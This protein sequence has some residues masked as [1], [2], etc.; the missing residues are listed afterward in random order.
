VD[1]TGFVLR[2]VRADADFSLYRTE[3]PD[4]TTP[5]LVLTASGAGPQR[6]LRLEREWSLASLLDRP[7]A[8]RPV[9]LGQVGER[10]ALVLED[11]GGEPLEAVIRRGIPL[12]RMLR[13]ARR[14]ASALAKVHGAGL[15]HKDIRP[16]NLLVD[17]DDSVSVMGFGIASR[18]ARERQALRPPEV[19]DGCFAYMAPEQ[20]GRMNRTIDSRSDLYALGATLYEMLAGT[21]PFSA[22]EP[23]EW[24]HCHIA[25]LPRPP[26]EINPEISP[27]LERVVLKLLS[28]AA[29]DRYQTASGLAADL[30]RLNAFE[31]VGSTADFSLGAHDTHGS[32]RIPE[33]LYGREDQV[34]SLLAAFDRVVRRRSCELVLVSGYSGIGKSSVVHELYRAI[35]PPR[36][37]FASGKYDQSKR[38]VPYATLAQALRGLVR[39]VLG[40]NEATSKEWRESLNA[41]LG[42]NGRLMLDLVPDLELLLGKFPA[43]AKLPPRETQIR[44][45]MVFK[46]MLGV[47]ARPEHPLVLFLDDL[48]WLDSGTLTLLADVAT[49]RGVQSLLLIGAYRDNEVD[50]DHPLRSTLNRIRSAGAVC[51]EVVLTPLAEQNV[52]HLIEDA[53]HS[54]SEG[55]ADLARLAHEKTA[56]NPFFLL[57][58]LN[59]LSDEG[60]LTFDAGAGVWDA[61]LERIRAK[62][63]THNVVDL[64]VRRLERLSE[65]TRRMLTE[66]ACLGNA[67]SADTLSVVTRT[68]VGAVHDA[69]GDAVEASL[70]YE[71]AERYAFLH[72]RVQEAAYSLLG[73]DDRPRTHLRIGNRLAER[74]GFESLG[75]S[76]FEV[77]SHLNRA[78]AMLSKAEQRQLAEIN[79]EAGL[80]AKGAAAYGSALAYLARGCQLLTDADWELHYRLAFELELNLSECEFLTNDAESPAPRLARLWERARTTRDLARV[81][82]V[83]IW[84]LT[85]VNRPTEAIGI[86]LAYLKR[87][88]VIWT[89]APT[90]AEVRAEY[91]HLLALMEQRAIEDLVALPELADPDVAATLDIF[92]AMLPAASMLDKN[93]FDRMV[94]RMSTLSIE[95]GN[96]P[97]T[98]L[99]FTYLAMALPLRFGDRERAYRFAEVGVKLLERP[100][101]ER[102]GGRVLGGFG[103]HVM[104]WTKPLPRALEMV[105]AGNRAAHEAGD[106]AYFGYTAH[107]LVAYLIATGAPL[108]DVKA[109][110]TRLLGF[111]RKA[112]FELVTTSLVGMLGVVE[113]LLG[114]PVT[115]LDEARLETDPSLVLPACW[116]FIRQVQR[117][118]LGGDFSEAMRYVPKVESLMWTTRTFWDRAEYLFYCG[119]AHAVAGDPN[120]AS[121]LERELTELA[122]RC[123]WTFA[124][125]A[126]LVAAELA[127]REGRLADAERHYDQA[128]AAAR[129]NRQLPEQALALERA[130]SFYAVRKLFSV[131]RSLLGCALE[132]YQRWGA[133]GKAQ[134]LERRPGMTLASGATTATTLT[135]ELDLAALLSVSQALSGE[136][137]LERLI[138]RLMRL[139]VENA[140]ADR[141]LLLRPNGAEFLVEAMAT[142]Q[143]ERVEVQLAKTLVSGAELPESLVRFVIRTREHVLLDDAF[144]HHSHATDVY[145]REQRCRSL[146]CLPLLKLG[147]CVGVLYLENSLA[148]HV[149]TPAR[150]AVLELLAAQAA[151][152]LENARL[153]ANLQT[154]LEEKEA[155]LKEVHH[156]VKNNLQLISSLLNLQASR[157]VDPSVAELFADSR[158]RVRSMA[159]VHENLYRTGSFT[160]VAIARHVQSLC[161]H[162]SRVYDLAGRRIELFTRIGDMELDLDQA[163]CVGLIVNELVTNAVKH[164]FPDQRAGTVHVEFEWDPD[165]ACVLSVHDD[166]VG[167]PASIDFANCSS[168][169]LQLVHDLTQQLHGELSI[170]HGP[171]SRFRLH[172]SAG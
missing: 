25:R 76:V 6:A 147:Q 49:D 32:L 4:G 141:A 57:Q 82:I 80:R 150:I 155:L 33:K 108:A 17:D 162:L 61:K 66:L 123:P 94:I 11:P 19:I 37:L 118:V 3:S 47:F 13:I 134:A 24:I 156:R 158:N 15:I 55:T 2:Q 68:P 36:G 35:V 98:C 128:I 120:D 113:S 164:A 60:L 100:G 84:L 140:G 10:P 85:T 79:L 163:V 65:P 58:F 124:S 167:L 130:A 143:L 56:G 81:A 48:Q 104:C 59:A 28:K 127:R 93:L 30:E 83:R 145:L 50:A 112:Q 1:L 138:E 87:V 54:S 14:L 73:I 41:A 62:G 39:Y 154:S 152:S 132:A 21:P 102:F 9:S 40:T 97:T 136:I 75:D 139:A 148:P 142:V 12:A 137:V 34:A 46:R 5:W 92:D 159:L 23:M 88:C 133:R 171:S 7:W 78:V 160:R 29:E 153:Y 45:Q 166:G 144:A 43:I 86:A 170:T 71:S 20:T 109:E 72:D 74:S 116:Y 101:S 135:K 16:A 103:Y 89:V 149:F 44:F 111:T 172:F 110:T 115:P 63:H 18:L 146:L 121:A 114:E 131:E 53:L 52:R 126:A 8:V 91:E 27:L 119:L 106:V 107:S 95:K 70:V 31:S 161:A 26:R 77:V 169:G 22:R 96:A 42:T 117:H 90:D 105:R 122:P 69:L 168:M 157:I 129:E 125:R 99:A 51:E 67:A 38:D 165:G 64:L 151:I